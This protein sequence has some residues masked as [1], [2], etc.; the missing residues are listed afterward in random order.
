MKIRKNPS[1]V[2]IG[3]GTG[4]YSLLTGLKEYTG[5][6]SAVVNMVDSGGSA[7]KERD[8]WG[9][10]PSSDVR[11]SLLALSDVST[12]DSLLLRKLFQYRYDKGVGVAGMTFG[13]LFL[14]A[15]T[16]LLGSQTKAIEKAGRLL[17]IKGR[18]L[19]VTM[20][21]VDLVATYEDGTTVVGEHFIDEPKHNGQVKIKKL[22]LKP[23]ALITPQAKEAIEKS[24]VLLIG[25]GGFYTTILAT[26]IVDGVIAAIMKSK[27]KKIFIMN[28]MT[29]YGQTFG[30]SAM[31]FLKVLDTYLPIKLL[32]YIFI[33]N[34]PIPPKI[35]ERYQKYHAEPVENNLPLS[36]KNKIVAADL[37]SNKVVRRQKGDTLIRSFIRHS[38][39]KI[40]ALCIK[41]LNS[42]IIEKANT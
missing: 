11:K 33:N 8:E 28:L 2:V 29:E 14:V 4:T 36:L 34:K 21:T 22:M 24:D 26:L 16:K 39:E 38:P 20:D 19:P 42:A 32:D 37:L 18:V 7:K 5:N 35:L 13:N 6:I 27:A 12:K 1:F 23:Q 41:Y 40:S 9:L 15:L 30:F 17:K 10:L 31:D 25:P 3:G